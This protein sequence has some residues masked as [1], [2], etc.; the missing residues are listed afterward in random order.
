[1]IPSIHNP[2]RLVRWS[3]PLAVFLAALLL[4]V[5][6]LNDYGVT[7][8]EPPYFHASDLHTHWLLQFGNKTS[9]VADKN[10]LSDE[11]I[12]AGWRWNPY[13]VPHPPFSRI[14][15]AVTQ[16][17]FY[18]PLDKIAAY[19][20][21]PALFFASLVT[22]MFLWIGELFGRA[23]GLF[24]ALSL[25]LIPNLFGYAHI[26]VTDLPLASL[27]F[28]TS[29]CFWKGLRDWKWSVALG[30]IWGLALATKFPALLIPIPL[31]AWAHLFHRDKYANNLIAMLFLAP[32]VMVASQPYLWH[33]TGL[34]LIEFLYE[35]LSRA[36]RP[37]T[38]FAIYFYGDKYLTNQLPRYYPLFV[39]GVTTPETILL[40][41]LVGLGF[42]PSR[43]ENRAAI[44]LFALN[45]LFVIGLGIMPG[46]V[47]HDGVRQLLS[48]LAF[49]AALAGGGFHAVTR[50]ASILA[51]RSSRLRRVA[52]L[53]T[54]TVA[55]LF[56]LLSFSPLV[57]L[58]LCHP[59]QLSYYNRFVGGIRGAYDRGLEMTYFM[60][61][62]T[63]AFVNELN[64][65]LP[66]NAVIN[67]SF[68]NF[69]FT[70]YKKIGLLR[71]DI[72]I[73]A[74]KRFDYFVLLNRRSVLPPRE[75]QLVNGSVRP[76][77][78]VGVAGVPLV[79]VFAF[80]Q[81]E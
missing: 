26:A 9:G 58:Y 24:S 40:L 64:Q 69:M 21:A 18:P 2:S 28:I 36:Y 75:N 46:A 42:V 66:T 15:S 49:F 17:V 60:E 32:A 48:A 51:Q 6:T 79:A 77:L 71:S 30:M 65:K 70:Y 80:K 22:V 57:D 41:A 52:N 67:A 3:I 38:N 54:K 50:W 78:S 74:G 72:D 55:I 12:K 8:D 27:W 56:L 45:A 11:A 16:Y 1:M 29:Y 73:T 81:P 44:V 76:H 47:L 33:Q 23:A 39:I 68:A 20:L 61:A 25:I 34:R 37:D 62:F 31:I 43:Q 10:P 14:V 59:F 63:P 4:V 53:E 7:W 13:N 19:R 35:G 5:A